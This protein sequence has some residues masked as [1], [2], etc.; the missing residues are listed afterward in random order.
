MRVLS[1]IE[2]GLCSVEQIAQHENLRPEQ[3]WP[4]LAEL[5]ELRIIEAHNGKP[6]GTHRRPP[7]HYTMRSA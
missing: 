7:K 1:C 3:I 2:R 6:D 4:R 5:R